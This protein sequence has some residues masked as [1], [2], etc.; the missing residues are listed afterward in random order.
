MSYHYSGHAL[1]QVPIPTVPA[2]IL[3]AME[4]LLLH[5][6]YNDGG[7]SIVKIF[8]LYWNGIYFPAET[9]S[10]SLKQY[11]KL[12]AIF[13]EAILK[14]LNTDINFMFWFFPFLGK[15]S[16]FAT[17]LSV[18]QCY[19]SL[20]HTFNLAFYLM[21]WLFF[22][23]NAKP[24]FIFIFPSLS[25][26]FSQEAYLYAHHHHSSPLCNTRIM[27]WPEMTSCVPSPCSLSG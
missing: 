9:W 5:K 13:L 17:I 25:S 18:L 12:K 23:P 4:N 22:I 21:S 7:S 14:S 10:C 24:F 20:F 15:T 1:N 3:L 16:L 27:C 11:R 19:C 26:S 8:F 2:W 6:S